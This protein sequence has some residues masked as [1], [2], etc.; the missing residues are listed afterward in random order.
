MIKEMKLFTSSEKYILDFEVLDKETGIN[1]TVEGLGT[2]K[3][4]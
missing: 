4:I 3:K 1:V 2:C